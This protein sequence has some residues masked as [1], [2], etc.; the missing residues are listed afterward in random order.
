MQAFAQDLNSIVDD[1]FEQVDN[2]MIQHGL[3]PT[4]LEEVH[5]GFEFVRI[6]LLLIYLRF[7]NQSRFSENLI[8]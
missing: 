6:T 4:E 3:D 5:E 2:Y 8:N 1:I 7:T